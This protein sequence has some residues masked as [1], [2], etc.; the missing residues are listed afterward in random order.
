[1]TD[2]IVDI[3]SP[4]PSEVPETPE[5]VPVKNDE[6]NRRNWKIALGGAV[7]YI[8]YYFFVT[9]FNRNTELA[10]GFPIIFWIL[11][12]PIGAAAYL[13]VLGYTIRGISR[14]TF[15][16]RVT[17]LLFFVTLITYLFANPLS[18]RVLNALFHG[19]PLDE[20]FALTGRAVLPMPLIAEAALPFLLILT[21]VFLGQLIAAMIKEP[22]ML[23]PVGLVASLVDIWGVFWGPMKAM[24]ESSTGVAVYSGFGS[25]PTAT[26]T[27][28]EN[29]VQQIPAGIAQIFTQIAPPS[30]IGL[31]DFVFLA[32]FL[33]CAHRLGFS[34]RRTMWGIVIGFMISS[35]IFALSGQDVGGFSL[36]R[37]E[38]LPGLP[39]ICG[40][41]LLANLKFWQLSKSEKLQTFG[42]SLALILIFG[43]I[44]YIQ[45][46]N[47]PPSTN[48]RHEIKITIK[49]G[50]N[51]EE[52]YN[53][54]TS[55]LKKHIKFPSKIVAIRLKIAEK[56]IVEMN[57]IALITAKVKK[58]NEYAD[59][60]LTSGDIITTTKDY[61]LTLQM[62]QPVNSLE[63]AGA[64]EKTPVPEKEKL[65]QN[66]QAIPLEYYK[67]IDSA[68]TYTEGI[69]NKEVYLR[70]RANGLSLVDTGED[71]ALI[72]TIK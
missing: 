10:A 2:D 68:L 52:I 23:I 63:I 46:V 43:S 62:A 12:A 55:G 64:T 61:G 47:E 69:K 42:V 32:F 53:L 14:L 8:L 27:M 66:L 9:L 34:T 31:G 21:G 72:K 29:I 5:V 19:R 15:T 35:V 40:G 26:P 6:N 24:S 45:R 57:V 51:G 22:A 20:L 18:R 54:V 38:Y 71:R 60:V 41:A 33:T 58:K 67:Y 1:M 56:K 50:A 17:T 30:Q 11:I 49:G 37:I 59:I 44:T 7:L 4:E 3:E 28:P 65:L 13:I 48:I 16:I 25:A 70:I 39:F 36:P